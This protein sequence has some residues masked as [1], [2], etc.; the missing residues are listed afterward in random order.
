MQVDL[1]EEVFK[2]RIAEVSEAQL[3]TLAGG[4][5]VT[6]SVPICSCHWP[7]SLCTC[8]TEYAGFLAF[9]LGPG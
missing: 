6:E 5:Q 1:T 8:V 4:E 9:Q 7:A 2:V 3:P